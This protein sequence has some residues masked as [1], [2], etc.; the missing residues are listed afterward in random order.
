VA[1]TTVIAIEDGGL[2]R[3]YT[4]AAQELLQLLTAEATYD[5]SSAAGDF[6]PSVA[7][8]SQEGR[9]LA[10][11]FPATAI[12]AG[13]SAKVTFAPFLRAAG[14]AAGGGIQFDVD[15]VGGY[16]QVE[17]GANIPSGPLEPSDIGF[18]SNFGG[19]IGLWDGDT[20][21]GITLVTGPVTGNEFGGGSLILLAKGGTAIDLIT[22]GGIIDI[23]SGSNVTVAANGNG[24]VHAD[25]DLSLTAN[26][27]TF[28]TLPTSDPGILGALWNDGGTV[29]I[30]I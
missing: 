3:G 5:G 17:G 8:Y 19:G 16:L 13:D 10:R 18:Q 6:L 27:N 11:T 21:G 30:S 12:G 15:N 29:K 25:G 20:G 24:V 14:G 2:P 7:I 4:L 28:M 23:S 22:T 26:N 9:L 1:A